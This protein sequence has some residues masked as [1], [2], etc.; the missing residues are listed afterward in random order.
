MRKCGNQFSGE[1]IISKGIILRGSN[2]EIVFRIVFRKGRGIQKLVRNLKNMVI[3]GKFFR[4]QIFPVPVINGEKFCILGIAPVYS[5]RI[6]DGKISVFG[7]IEF[8]DIFSGNFRICNL[9]G[10]VSIN[11]TSVVVFPKP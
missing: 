8:V 10:L 6:E 5:F 1:L 7:N 4:P 2:Y 11:A 3:C 9:A